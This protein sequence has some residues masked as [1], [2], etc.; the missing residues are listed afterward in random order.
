MTL[1]VVTLTIALG[2]SFVCSVLEAALL[3][4]TPSQVEGMAKQRPRAAELWRG[5]K[6]N[7]EKP[8]AVILILNTTA[9]T[10]GAS[11]SGAQFETLYGTQWLFVFSLVLTYFM[12]QFTE[13]LPK[14]LGVSYNAS[15]APLVAR[16]LA[17]LVRF[18]SPVLWFIHFVNR[19]FER[20]QRQSGSSAAA[21]EE[22]QALA[23]AARTADAIDIHQSRLITAASRLQ[24]LRVRQIMTPRTEMVYLTLGQPVA[25]I[26]QCVQKT[27]YTRLPLC[28]GDVDHIIGM[29][30]VR[31]L[32]NH[33]RLMPGK[34]R[35]QSAEGGE[36]VAIPTA[37]PGSALHVIGSGDLDLRAIRRNVLFV[38][39]QAAVPGVLRQFQA[40]RIHMAVVVNEYGA[41]LG[42]VTLED[43]IEEMIGD[44]RDEFDRPAAKAIEPTPTGYR[45]SGGLPLAE[46]ESLL[47]V[48]I[49][50]DDVDT[51][52][53][54][55]LRRLGRLPEVGDQVS[56]GEY[57]ARVLALDRRRI[58]QVELVRKQEAATPPDADA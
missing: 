23:A 27:Q 58:R 13:I 57:E 18:L 29:I 32:F 46:V 54:Y 14:T 53:G 17:W 41:T 49:P 5:M 19:P 37:N 22:I 10:I 44:I 52:G 2:T 4:L 15:L 31:D 51:L 38:P 48:S 45:V 26:L 20:R 28:E 7:I 24:G 16:P 40:S 6:R 39:D 55:I 36:A 12:L 43:V 42:V 11:V 33:L 25:E 34:L 47:K 21:M 8:I 1:L 30:H 9:H 50:D 35:I 56:I 3:S